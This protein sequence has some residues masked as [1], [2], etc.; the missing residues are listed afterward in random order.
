MNK[1]QE[2]PLRFSLQSLMLVTVHVSLFLGAVMWALRGPELGIQ[3]LVDNLML[4]TPIGLLFVLW[5][6]PGLAI[7]PL[8]TIGIMI[9][10][11]VIRPR[12][13]GGYHFACV[14]IAVITCVCLEESIKP[15]HESYIRLSIFA[16]LAAAFWLSE[17]QC[18]E[19]PRSNRDLAVTALVTAVSY[20][21]LV[22]SFDAIMSV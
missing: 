21:I 1:S 22:I 17:T 11:I 10:I 6:I 2:S 12:Q 16:C 14:A 20:F 15:T 18:R 4:E 13:Y 19:V 8:G 5:C 7:V 3:R 9:S